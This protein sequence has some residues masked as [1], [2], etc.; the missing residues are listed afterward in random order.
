[1]LVRAFRVKPCWKLK[2]RCA[3]EQ[4]NMIKFLIKENI[5]SAEI[6]RKTI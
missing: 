1:M 4:T 6:N 2:V 5:K 3:A